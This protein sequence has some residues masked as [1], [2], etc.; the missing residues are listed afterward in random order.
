MMVAP[1]RTP[2]SPGFSP[3]LPPRPLYEVRVNTLYPRWSTFFYS[4]SNDGER[5]LV[6]QIEAAT[7]PGINVVVNWEEAVLGSQ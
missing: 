3:V 2:A 5:F 6:N 7:E 1:M 4:V